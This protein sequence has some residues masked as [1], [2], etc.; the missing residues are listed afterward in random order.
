MAR[1]GVAGALS[2]GE[3]G[4]VVLAIF[5]FLA[6]KRLCLLTAIQIF[7][8]LIACVTCDRSFNLLCLNSPIL[9]TIKY[10]CFIMAVKVQRDCARVVFEAGL[11]KCS[12]CCHS[13]GGFGPP[14]HLRT[15]SLEEG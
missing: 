13:G 4:D 14:F 8:M 9:E 12:V 15:S 11:S 5:P 10:M 7:G 6:S 3:D 1:P 2:P